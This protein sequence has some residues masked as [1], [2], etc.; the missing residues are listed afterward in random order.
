MNVRTIRL[1]HKQEE[2][3]YNFNK[4]ALDILGV[5]DHKI[6]HQESD[7]ELETRNI[8]NTTFITSSAWRTGSGSAQGG[9][10]IMINKS[11]ERALA[12]VKKYSPR[13]IVAHF[14]GNETSKSTTDT[15]VVVNYAPVEGSSEAEEHYE[16]LA[17]VISEIPKHNL[18]MVIGDFN[19]HI[20]SEDAQHTFHSKTNHN[21]QLLLDLT[22][23]AN[24][25]ITNT[26][27]QK[28]AGKLWTYVSDMAGTKSQ[29][30]YILVNRK[31]RNS[32]KNVEAYNSFSSMGSDH[33]IVCAR[34]KLSLRVAK[35]P[36]RSSF[37]W[38][39]LR[40]TEL[41][42]VYTEEVR[43]RY[44][45]LCDP[46]NTPTE[47][48]D[49]LIAANNHAAEK[50]LPKKKRNR[51]S[52]ISN[53]PRISTARQKVQE[54]FAEY[55]EDQ[56]KVNQSKLQQE[57]NDLQTV[58]DAITHEELEEMIRK[59][60][61]AGEVSKHGESWKLINEISGRKTAKKGQLSGKGKEDRLKQWHTHFSN[62][63]GKEPDVEGN[64]DEDIPLVF[65]ALDIKTGPFDQG[66]LS[67]AKKSLCEG[68]SFG[69]DGIP[70][71]VLTRC[72]LDDI[73]LSYANGL[74]TH[75]EK[76]DQWSIFNLIPVPKSG[77][78]GDTENY[79][80]IALSVVM[81]KLT[82]KMILNRLLILD[83]L[84]R[85]NQNGFRP[86]RSMMSYILALR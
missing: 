60:E 41:Q 26:T 73:I 11:A 62:L 86:G 33:R 76:P 15:S 85:P 18:L 42:K 37:E 79:R 20:G 45:E 21:G 4:A 2:L 82:N 12:E 80:G 16:K 40:C 14:S 28:K 1:K 50:L 72:E 67:K 64:P 5:V 3:A 78:L 7:A 23:E 9:V 81:A 32:V 58:Y 57:K 48:Y 66:E 56:N 54:A 52:R 70:V 74:L 69:N 25:L 55:S 63:F 8:E 49:N 19:A 65:E 10:G 53:D 35:T 36:P 68:K 38:S 47:R 29:V 59:V 30:D 61:N 39:A 71:E 13:I 43:N 46:S 31:W 24:L 51:R 27:F 6:V 34:V 22:Q 75:H 17:G 77:D 83:K 84:L 44:A